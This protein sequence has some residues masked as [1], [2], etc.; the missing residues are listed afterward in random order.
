[1]GQTPKKKIFKK[2]LK[3]KNSLCSIKYDIGI[4]DA[5][6]MKIQGTG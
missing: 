2:N 6:G 4:I 5:Q 1:M 3:K